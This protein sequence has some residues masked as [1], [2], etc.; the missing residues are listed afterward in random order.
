LA[1]VLIAIIFLH[2]VSAA[3]AGLFWVAAGLLIVLLV[4]SFTR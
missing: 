3:L 4:F 2:F 1:L